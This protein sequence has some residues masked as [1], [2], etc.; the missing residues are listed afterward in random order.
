M[1]LPAVFLRKLS[2][3]WILN[4]IYKFRVFFTDY[5]EFFC[6]SAVFLRTYFYPD[7]LKIYHFNLVKITRFKLQLLILCCI[8]KDTVGKYAYLC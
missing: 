1:L 4:N 6:F 3:N 8:I 5:T 2:E 7:I